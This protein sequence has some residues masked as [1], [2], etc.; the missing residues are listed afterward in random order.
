M[1]KFPVPVIPQEPERLSLIVLRMGSAEALDERGR[2]VIKVEERYREPLRQC[3]AE[4]RLAA[5]CSACDDENF[6]HAITLP[7]AR[8]FTTSVKLLGANLPSHLPT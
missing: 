2:H 1:L 7:L 8:S 4:R 6:T 3:S 5:A